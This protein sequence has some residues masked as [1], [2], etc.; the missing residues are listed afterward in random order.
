M[1]LGYP[2]AEVDIL[3]R[4][5]QSADASPD[6]VRFAAGDPESGPSLSL[7]FGSKAVVR[8]PYRLVLP[9]VLFPDFAIHVRHSLFIRT[10]SVEKRKVDVCKRKRI[11]IGTRIG[12]QK[13]TGATKCAKERKSTN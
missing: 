1:F 9:A 13:A 12:K 5:T 8:F 11:I 3:R 2:A 7:E 4:V 6:G 10:Q